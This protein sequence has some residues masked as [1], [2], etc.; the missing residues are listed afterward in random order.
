MECPVEWRL[1]HVFC[2]LVQEPPYDGIL[3]AIVAVLNVAKV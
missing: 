1:S 3:F 2:V